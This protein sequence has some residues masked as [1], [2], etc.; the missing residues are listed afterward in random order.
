MIYVGYVL[1]I[2]DML[3]AKFLPEIPKRR[4]HF[5]DLGVNEKI[6]LEWY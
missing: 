6:I 5:V 1:R 4:I 2:R 3:N